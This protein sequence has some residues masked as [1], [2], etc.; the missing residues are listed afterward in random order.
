MLAELF[1]GIAFSPADAG[2]ST[3][4]ATQTAIALP[5]CALGATALL[6]MPGGSTGLATSMHT[7]AGARIDTHLLGRRRLQLL[8]QYQTS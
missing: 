7:G 4:P 2:R 5:I 1:V 3:T 8:Y 6:P